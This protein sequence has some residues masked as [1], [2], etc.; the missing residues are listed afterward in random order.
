MLRREFLRGVVPLSI[1]PKLLL[2]QQATGAAPPP[3]APVPW[4]LGLS[5]ATPLPHTVVADEVAATELR[6]FS[7]SQM[8]TL[9]RLS[10][11]LLP[12]LAGKPGALQAQAPEFLDFLIGS[13]AETRKQIYATG[14]DWLERE[15]MQQFGRSFAALDET[16]SG[17][18]L[19]PWLRSWMTD[20]PP[21]EPHADFVNIVHAD[22]RTATVNS[23]QWSDAPS[24]SAT[25][26]TPTEL[27]WQPI[28]PDLAG[29]RV[30][31][32][33]KPGSTIAAPSSE[34]TMPTYSR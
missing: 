3:P 19:R 22:I 33:P 15:A 11:V 4:T 12:P 14:L 6:F 7:A 34:H 16:Q 2:A 25:E 8:A 18:L 17:A 20:H 32:G 31:W 23:R 1:A 10:D 26:R 24:S 27:F 5:P 29:N 28:E 9:R 21:L 30:A 13:S